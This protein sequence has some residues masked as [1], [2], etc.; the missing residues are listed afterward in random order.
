MADT[1]REL[2]WDDPIDPNADGFTLLEPG[3]YDFTVESWT[4]ARFGGSPKQPACNQAKLRI[5]IADITIEHN[6]FLH[7]KN[8]P[9]LCQFFKAIGQRGSGESIIPNWAKVPGST[10][11][12]QLGIRDWKGKDGEM[13]Q[14][15]EIKKFLTNDSANQVTEADEL[16]F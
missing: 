8:M 9:F 12:C 6:L 7:S 13:R 4:K 5:R 14:S 10:G 2:G 16:A 3:E 15:N 1:G 11:R